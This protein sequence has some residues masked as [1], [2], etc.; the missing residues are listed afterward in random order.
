[1]RALAAAQPL[2][3]FRVILEELEELLHWGY[4]FLLA[5]PGSDA[6]RQLMACARRA[7]HALAD[8]DER[9]YADALAAYYRTMLVEIR[10]YLAQTG[11]SA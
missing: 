11:I 4:V 7:A 2:Q 6:R 1:M 8:G 9:A 10:G 5:R 3:P